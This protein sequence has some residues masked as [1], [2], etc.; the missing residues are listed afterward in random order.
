MNFYYNEKTLKLNKKALG[1]GGH[2]DRHW[3]TS[4]VLLQ[5]VQWTPH[6]NNNVYFDF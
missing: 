2:L 3:V 1:G 6:N 5:V 4:I